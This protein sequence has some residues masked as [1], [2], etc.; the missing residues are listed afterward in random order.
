VLDVSRDDG[1][2]EQEIHSLFAKLIE[3]FHPQFWQF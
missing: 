3:E 1:M 2:D